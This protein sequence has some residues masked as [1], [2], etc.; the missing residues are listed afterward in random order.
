MGVRRCRIFILFSVAWRGRG[1]P[2]R[3]HF[4]DAVRHFTAIQIDHKDAAPNNPSKI[5][6]N[7]KI[8]PNF[9]RIQKNHSSRCH[10]KREIPPK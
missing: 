1:M 8:F 6:S 3:F 7:S 5:S 4:L 9:I 10:Q 2:F